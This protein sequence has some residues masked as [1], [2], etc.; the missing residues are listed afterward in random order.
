[1]LALTGPIVSV[2]SP[3]GATT[4]F[5]SWVMPLMS[6]ELNSHRPS[7]FE[8]RLRKRT[9][10]A[11]TRLSPPADTSRTTGQKTVI[12]LVPWLAN[13]I[14]LTAL[15]RTL[16]LSLLDRQFTPAYP[17]QSCPAT[18]ACAGLNETRRRPRWRQ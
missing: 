7:T 14:W 3:N 5:V 4:D 1:M 17:F 18:S 10:T 9:A 8:F 2:F 16:A 11:V 13:A 12:V 15:R 6:R